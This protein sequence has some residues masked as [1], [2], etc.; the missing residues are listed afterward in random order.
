MSTGADAGSGIGADAG[1]GAD[2]EDD[3]LPGLDKS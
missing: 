1:A 2:S 3:G